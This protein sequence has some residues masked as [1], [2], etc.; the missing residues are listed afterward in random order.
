MKGKKK[1]LTSNK[2]V[3]FCEL[4]GDG[5]MVDVCVRMSVLFRSGVA[6][7][8]ILWMPTSPWVGS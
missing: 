8:A 1:S 7:S 3:G 5:E 6:G 2:V 4:S